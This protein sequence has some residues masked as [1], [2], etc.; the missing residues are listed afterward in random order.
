[1]VSYACIGEVSFAML[2]V[3]IW[4]YNCMIPSGQVKTRLRRA[5]VPFY[6]PL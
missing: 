4:G 5:V 1:M 3:S 6:D 2:M